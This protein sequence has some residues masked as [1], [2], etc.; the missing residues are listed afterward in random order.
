LDNEDW[1]LR[2]MAAMKNNPLT[3]AL[4][5]AVLVLAVLCAVCLLR[6]NLASRQF[7]VSQAKVMD[8]NNKGLALRSLAIELNDYAKRHPDI[9]P[10]LAARNMKIVNSNAP[11]T[12]PPAK[13]GAK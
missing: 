8:L 4:L 1:V 10:I 5:G 6:Y 2:L 7:P 12:N 13:A 11:A 3:T 9:E